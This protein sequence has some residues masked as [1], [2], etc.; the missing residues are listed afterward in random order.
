[1][2]SRRTFL[3]NLVHWTLLSRGALA[4]PLDRILGRPPKSYVQAYLRRY[5]DWYQAQW[6]DFTNQMSSQ[7]KQLFSYWLKNVETFGQPLRSDHYV[8]NFLTRH[9]LI[10][11][12]RKHSC[13]YAGL[14]SWNESGYKYVE[15][16]LQTKIKDFNL[17]EWT[18]GDFFGWS[19][20]VSNTTLKIWFKNPLPES[21]LGTKRDQLPLLGF[22]EFKGS[23]E[24][25]RGLV[26]PASDFQDHLPKELDARLVTQAFRVMDSQ[27]KVTWKFRT[28]GTFLPVLKSGIAW[29][30]AQH[31][32]EFK[33]IADFIDTRGADELKVYYP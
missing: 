8:E 3:V 32:S 31:H 2:I 14:P 17:S 1:M 18:V 9:H 19:H 24:K 25:R 13:Y 4:Y 20:D 26:F 27:Q 22:V 10:A 30:A 29:I 15:A 33:Q 5:W 7:E 12:Q 28:K 23:E 21:F 16:F 11:D 6:F